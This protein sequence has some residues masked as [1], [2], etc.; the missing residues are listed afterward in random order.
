MWVIVEMKYA[1]SDGKWLASWHHPVYRYPEII[2]GPFRTREDAM[3]V[4]GC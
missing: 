2:L 1:L 3:S 4:L